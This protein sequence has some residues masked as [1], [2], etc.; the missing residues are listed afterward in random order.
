MIHLTSG[1][2]VNSICE[3]STSK[4]RREVCWKKNCL[5]KLKCFKVSTVGLHRMLYCL[6]ISLL[7]LLFLLLLLCFSIAVLRLIELWCLHGL[8][9]GITVL[10]GLFLLLFRFSILSCNI[11]LGVVSA[12]GCVS[13]SRLPFLVLLFLFLS[14]LVFLVCD[15][16]WIIPL[17]VWRIANN[18]SQPTW[19]A[20]FITSMF[21]GGASPDS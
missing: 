2:F 3:S 15:L 1:F 10:L 17:D 4:I 6:L 19:I 13:V 18:F 9:S 21:L 8:I 16:K 5:W 20:S 14:T 12:I 11:E 7:L